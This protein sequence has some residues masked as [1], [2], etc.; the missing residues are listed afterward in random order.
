[1][2][3]IVRRDGRGRGHPHPLRTTPSLPPREQAGGLLHSET[4]KRGHPAQPAC[5]RRTPP[6]SR[7]NNKCSPSPHPSPQMQPP[8][9]H[10]PQACARPA[11]APRRGCGNK[12][13][14]GTGLSV[15]SGL[16]HSAPPPPPLTPSPPRTLPR[17]SPYEEWPPDGGSPG[18]PLPSLPCSR[19][20]RRSACD[21]RSSLLAAAY[22]RIA[23]ADA[24]AAAAAS[25]ATVGVLAPAATPGP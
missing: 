18:A 22:A 8:P 25:T 5:V 4:S 1:M 12:T 15:A 24:A 13:K 20:A 21:S 16:H 7:S 10:S 2:P 14:T 23:L 6:A 17:E 9:Q 19:R 3:R 11:V